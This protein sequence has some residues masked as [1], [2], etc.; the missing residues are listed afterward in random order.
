MKLTFTRDDRAGRTG[1]GMTVKDARTA[2]SDVR[3][4][5]GT[6]REDTP[7]V[8]ALLLVARALDSLLRDASRGEMSVAIVHSDGFA[9]PQTAI[10]TVRREIPA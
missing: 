3:Y 4:Y 5:A 6:S 8:L 10:D 7:T 2:R 9:S 1:H